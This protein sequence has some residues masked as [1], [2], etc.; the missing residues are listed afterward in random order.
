MNEVPEMVSTKDL[1]YIE[2]MLNWNFIA[3]KKINSYLQ[4]INDEEINE[5]FSYI[6]EKYKEHYQSI[7]DCL[8]I[9]GTDE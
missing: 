9:G 7:I 3:V 4:N 2:D 1:A 6:S 5:L 8:N